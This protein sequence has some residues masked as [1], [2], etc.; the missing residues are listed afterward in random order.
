[1]THFLLGH[2]KYK[3]YNFERI[4]TLQSSVN[5][6]DKLMFLMFILSTFHISDP[7][8]DDRD[9]AERFHHHIAVVLTQEAQEEPESEEDQGRLPAENE[10]HA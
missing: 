7:A 1:M 6:Y 5:I 8:V 4:G 9:C 2:F 10:V 3:I